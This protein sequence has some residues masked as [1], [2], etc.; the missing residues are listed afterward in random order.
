VCVFAFL[1]QKQVKYVESGLKAVKARN[2]YLL[3]L[4]AANAALQKYFS[5]DIHELINVRQ[6]GT[7]LCQLSSECC[8]EPLSLNTC[9]ILYMQCLLAFMPNFFHLNSIAVDHRS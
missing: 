6:S 4:E 9:I 2:E 3:C 5:E 7:Q 8:C 1:V